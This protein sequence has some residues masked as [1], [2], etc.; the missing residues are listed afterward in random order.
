MISSC[1]ETK[2]VYLAGSTVQVMIFPFLFLCL[3]RVVDL[4]M[5][6]LYVQV[7]LNIGMKTVN[8][9]SVLQT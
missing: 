7:E 6:I 3:F 8:L 4:Q 2:D 1:Y 9:P 5:K